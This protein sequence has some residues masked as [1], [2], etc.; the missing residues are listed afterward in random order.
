MRFTILWL[1]WAGTIFAQTPSIVDFTHFE[2]ASVRLAAPMPGPPGRVA[3]PIIDGGVGTSDPGQIAYRGIWLPTLIDAAFD[4]RSF[5]IQGPEWLTQQRYDIVAKIPAGA[6]HAQFNVMLQN[7]LRERFNL[8]VHH[9]SKIFPVYALTVGKNGFKLKES[10]RVDEPGSPP[11]VGAR[12]DANGFPTFPLR[13]SGVAGMPS[14]GRM[15]LS[16]QRASLAKLTGMLESQLDHPIVDQTGLTGE[17][18]FKLEFEWY[19]RRGAA[20]DNAT[21]P[22]P[23]VFEVVEKALGLKLEP[24]KVPF[25]VLIIDRL[26]REPTPN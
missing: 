26:D 19:A 21:D 10:P 2:V 1:A 16:G 18:D 24:A 6:T 23:S 13:F 15:R 17:Y 20:A 9:E 12:L 14:P 3:A 25:D 11:A 8:A 5:Q 22:A 4:L 7:L